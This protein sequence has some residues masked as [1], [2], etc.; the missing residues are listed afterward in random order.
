MAEEKNHILGR[1]EELRKRLII[2]AVAVGIGFVLSYGFTESLFKILARP[3][4]ASLPPGEK[5]VFTSL[6]EAFFCY[7]KTAFLSGIFLSM[8]VI[9]YEMW[10]FLG[11]G[12]SKGR[13][14]MLIVPVILSIIFF[15]CGVLFGYF[16][17]FPF[18][19]KYLIGFTSGDVKALPSMGE[20]FHL[21]A[22]LLLAFGVTFQ[23]PLILTILGRMGMVS[24]PFL[25]KNRKYA[26]LLIFIG[27]AILTP[28]PDAINLFLMAGP[29]VILYEMSIWGVRIFGRKRV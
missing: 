15:T 4:M 2:C 12:Y 27:S 10:T 11:T 14:L 7:L 16:A 13:K 21:C 26:I 8:P 1:L 3:L 5:M 9:M 25:R 22:I 6:P 24:V 18:A 23:L 20:Y 19:F 29:L 28:T 17:V